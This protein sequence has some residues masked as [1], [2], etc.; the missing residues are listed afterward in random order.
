MA[1]SGRSRIGFLANAKRADSFCAYR[2]TCRNKRS[3]C[4]NACRKLVQSRSHSGGTSRHGG[5]EKW[6]KLSCSQHTVKTTGTIR[7]A[8]RQGIC[9]GYRIFLS[10]LSDALNPVEGTRS[11]HPRLCQ[12]TKRA[13][14]LAG[15]PLKVSNTHLTICQGVTRDPPF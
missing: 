15:R 8:C 12:R 6:V 11:R 1:L 13:L 7:R 10:V 3:G 9:D 14:C 2:K 4:G 5:S